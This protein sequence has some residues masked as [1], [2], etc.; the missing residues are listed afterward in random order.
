MAGGW[1][2]SNCKLGSRS[3]VQADTAAHV[4]CDRID[5]VDLL[6]IPCLDAQRSLQRKRDLVDRGILA[7]DRGGDSRN[8]P[9]N[10]EAREEKEHNTRSIDREV[11]DGESSVSTGS[12]SDDHSDLLNRFGT[13]C[14]GLA[15]RDGHRSQECFACRGNSNRATQRHEPEFHSR[16]R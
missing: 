8:L 9:L 2:I 1:A 10:L 16:H 3:Y 6:W 14:L 13:N 11:R 4:N 5:C 7:A 12:A 15:L